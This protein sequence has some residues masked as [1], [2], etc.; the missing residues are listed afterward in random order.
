MK[1]STKTARADL[2]CEGW[3]SRV[4]H[5]ITALVPTEQESQ[6]VAQYIEKHPEPELRR[7]SRRQGD[8]A[9][10]VSLTAWLDCRKTG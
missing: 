3:C 4:Y 6:L 1:T 8:Q 9:R 5:K 7:V 10:S 2:F